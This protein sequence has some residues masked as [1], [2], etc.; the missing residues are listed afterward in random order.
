MDEHPS[1]GATAAKPQKSR[2]MRRSIHISLLV[3]VG[4]LFLGLWALSRLALCWGSQAGILV[5]IFCNLHWA[6]VLALLVV[7]IVFIY[8]A[9]EL[10]DTEAME[11]LA[12]G[13]EAKMQL[14]QR[15]AA[16]FRAYRKLPRTDFKYMTAAVIAASLLVF[17]L[18]WLF[19][20]SPVV[21]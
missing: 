6:T 3:V 14:R 8:L 11:G 4:F 1:V 16:A 10:S 19:L 7:A 2:V 20:L 13:E 9:K 18:L 17:F 15:P 21:F 5:S 12:P